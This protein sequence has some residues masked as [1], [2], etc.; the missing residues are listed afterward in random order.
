MSEHHLFYIHGF[1]SSPQS[2]KAQVLA[3]FLQEQSHHLKQP[4]HYHVPALPYDP[5]RAMALLDEAVN[6]CL[7]GPQAGTV[8]L[9]GSSLGGFFGTWITEKYDVPMALIN[10]AVRPHILLEDYLG[11]NENVHTGEK[12]VFTEAHIHQFKALDIDPL[13]K[14]ERYYLL[15]QTGDE[16]LDY[17]QGVEKYQGCKQDIREGGNHGFD[18]FVHVLPDI[19]RFLD[20]WLEVPID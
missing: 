7:T 10:P 12:Y 8:G 2:A 17:R 5:Q 15:T 11:E 18:D 13:T 14:I 1:N 19:M 6:E 16:T 20:L 3:S 9:V 4:I